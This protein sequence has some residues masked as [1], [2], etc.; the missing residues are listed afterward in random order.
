MW[1]KCSGMNTFQMHCRCTNAV[2]STNRSS[3][4]LVPVKVRTTECRHCVLLPTL[5]LA[6]GVHL[7]QCPFCVYAT[8]INKTQI[9]EHSPGGVGVSV[10][11]STIKRKDHQSKFRQFT[12]RCKLL[13]SQNVENDVLMNRPFYS[14]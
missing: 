14:L 11:K 4:Y 1:I 5:T 7:C 8:V 2:L 10:S 6:S 12:S 9:K 13:V 3:L